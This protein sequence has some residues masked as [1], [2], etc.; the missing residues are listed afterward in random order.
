MS[1]PSPV[2]EESINK[3]KNKNENANKS[4]NSNSAALNDYLAEN[5]SNKINNNTNENNNNDNFNDN[6]TKRNRYNHYDNNND[7]DDYDYEMQ[8]FKP[9]PFTSNQKPKPYYIPQHPS[10]GPNNSTIHEIVPN[11]D[12][13]SQWNQKSGRIGRSDSSNNNINNTRQRTPTVSSNVLNIGQFYSDN[14]EHPSP[15]IDNNIDQL[16]VRRSSN[17]TNTI[18][19]N[20]GNVNISRTNTNRSAIQDYDDA[21]EKNNVPIIVKPKTLYQNPQ[22]PTVL[23]STYHPINRWSIVKNSYLKEFLAEFMG[24]MVMIIYGSAVVCQVL[25]A[26]KY[27]QKQF[28]D[29]LNELQG[30][31]DVDTGS[32]KIIQTLENLVSSVSGGTFDDIALGWA[33]AVVMGYFC[34]GGSA[35]SG[36]HLNPSI[37]IANFIYRGFPAQKVPIYIGAQLLGAF[38]GALILFIYYKEVIVQTYEEWWKTEA[39]ASMFCVVPKPYLSSSRQFISEFLCGAM[40]QAGVFGITDP[41]TCLSSDL[42][43]L[44]MFILIFMINA[45]LAYQTGTAMNM[46]RD[47]GPRLALYAVGFDRKMLWV[48][49]HHFFWVPIVSPIIGAI[50]GG[51]AYDVCIYQGHESP[52]NWPLAVYKEMLLK[53][54]FRRPGWSHRTKARTTS[55][56][57]GFSYGED[58]LN[59]NIS[60]IRSTLSDNKF[61]KKKK[62]VN[63]EDMPEK[64]VQFKSVHRVERTDAGIP[65]ILEE[66]E[67]IETTSLDAVHSAS[68]S[69]F[70]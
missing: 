62:P 43:P 13:S 36:A 11:L 34:A 14:L 61:N 60:A 7:D 15:T 69:S 45:S 63:E 3:N 40:L 28:N 70:D 6:A 5:A 22:T 8:D 41:Y 2:W 57:S 17:T 65:T 30:D 19:N 29:A 64:A 56:L 49:H 31:A 25:A 10:N 53:L 9:I 20:D 50:A 18:N 47:L 42:F 23:P 38:C 1:V 48:A 51:L 46:A 59:D 12:M 27:Q 37:T 32:I 52:V 4:N 55:E 66:Q 26:G 44:M 68:T 24:T 39:V 16:R 58:E 33:G 67:S 21:H 35:I 54:W